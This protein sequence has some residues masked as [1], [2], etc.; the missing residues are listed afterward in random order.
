MKRILLATS[1]LLLGASV[2]ASASLL[3][4]GPGLTGNSLGGI[5]TWSPVHQRIARR[6]AA[7]H[8]AQYG[9]VAQ[10]TSIYPRYGQYIGFDCRFPRKAPNVP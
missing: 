7:D 9:K 3:G 5:I 4:P 10:I 6:W 2:P 8:C 1:V